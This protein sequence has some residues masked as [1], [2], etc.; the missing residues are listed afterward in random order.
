MNNGRTTGRSFTLIELLIA[1]TIILILA[2]LLLP[3]LG[4]SK[5]KAR[6][7]VCTSNL[8]Q[9]SKSLFMYSDD[10]DGNLPPGP[11]VVDKKLGEWITYKNR[12]IPLQLGYLYHYNYIESAQM[13][14]C[15]SWKHPYSQYGVNKG[16]FGGYPRPGEKGPS[17]WWWM[18]YGYRTAPESGRPVHTSKDSNGTAIITDHWTRRGGNTAGWDKGTGYFGHQEGYVTVYLD[19]HA[20]FL[21]DDD[22]Y[23]IE[24]A[25][26]HTEHSKIESFWE[27][28]FDE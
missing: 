13:F 8:A 18:S 26:K 12:T 20:I 1:I 3:M 5:E 2:A 25:P 24:T 14:Y 17:S 23:I 19:G 15:P 11:P 22:Q 16:K 7:V 4:R 21:E 28:N 27:N 6:R 9:M 10:G